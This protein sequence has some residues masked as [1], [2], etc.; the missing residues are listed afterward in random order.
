MSLLGIYVIICYY[1]SAEK[2]LRY[3]HKI[4]NQRFDNEYIKEKLNDI[5]SYQSDALH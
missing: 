4:T 5:L 3:E 1:K 2:S